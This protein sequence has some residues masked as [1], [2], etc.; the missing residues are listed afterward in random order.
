MSYFSVYI[1]ASE[2]VMSLKVYYLTVRTD[3]DECVSPDLN[4]CHEA[5]ICNNTDGSY[6]CSCNEGYDGDGYNCTGR[7]CNIYT[8]YLYR[9]SECYIIEKQL[10]ILYYF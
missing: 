9:Q 7:K 5:G 2:H 4:E 1:D 6:D 3:I 8:L 10:E